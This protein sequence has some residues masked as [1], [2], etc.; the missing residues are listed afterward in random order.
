MKVKSFLP[1]LIVALAFAIGANVQKIFGD[2]KVE[3]KVVEVEVKNFPHDMSLG[4]HNP[5]TNS[6]A[7]MKCSTSITGDVD[8]DLS[9]FTDDRIQGYG[10]VR[11]PVDNL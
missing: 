3:T 5:V 9:V 4:F 7:A 11:V 2:P 6:K 10:C 8:M 1:Y